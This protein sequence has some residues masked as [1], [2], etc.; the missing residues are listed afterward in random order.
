MLYSWFQWASCQNAC[1]P[2]AL[3][4]FQSP[5]SITQRICAGNCWMCCPVHSDRFTRKLLKW[6][7]VIWGSYCVC[8]FT[9]RHEGKAAVDTGSWVS[10]VLVPSPVLLYLKM[11]PRETDPLRFEHGPLDLRVCP[12]PVWRA[13][14]RTE[15]L[16]LSEQLPDLSVNVAEEVHV[17][18]T[19]VHTF[20]LHQALTE[21]NLWLVPLPHDDELSGAE[22]SSG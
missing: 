20:V 3:M 5:L 11:E 19:A 1:Q 18:G 7:V 22:R 17:G 10:W 12:G 16:K 13:T 14:L 9:Q 8:V 2:Q 6:Q 21:Q 15:C 4:L